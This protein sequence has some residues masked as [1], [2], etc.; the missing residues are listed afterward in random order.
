MNEH[1]ADTVSGTQYVI[2]W[3]LMQEAIAGWHCCSKTNTQLL[4]WHTSF[5]EAKHTSMTTQGMKCLRCFLKRTQ[6]FEPFSVSLKCQISISSLKYAPQNSYITEQLTRGKQTQKR[7]LK[8]AKG[9]LHFK[10]KLSVG[11]A[12]WGLICSGTTL[13]NKL[14]FHNSF[15]KFTF[16]QVLCVCACAWKLNKLNIQFITFLSLK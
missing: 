12:N 10:E 14:Y 9:R 6:K 1:T 4:I 11:S 15:T 8:S 13:H 16:T 3:Q 7:K 2:Q 5:Y